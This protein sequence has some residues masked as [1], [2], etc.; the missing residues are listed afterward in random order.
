MGKFLNRKVLTLLILMSLVSLLP[1]INNY[2]FRGEEALRTMVAYEMDKMS[3]Y[4]QPTLLGEPYYNKP[5]L[6][7]WLIIVSSKLIPWS[8][9]TSRSVTLIALILILLVTYILAFNILNDRFA[10][11]MSALIFISFSDILFWYGYLAEIDITLT[12]FNTT[13][14]LFLILGYKK[15]KISL[16]AMS[17]FVIG[18]SFLLKGLPAYAFWV[19]SI[20]AIIIKYKYCY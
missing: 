9:L 19:L 18:L 6:F 15:A 14:L 10:A 16:L 1:N 4:I 17:G 7:N 3:N 8:E 11:L 5:P 13:S 2:Q 12:L 20:A